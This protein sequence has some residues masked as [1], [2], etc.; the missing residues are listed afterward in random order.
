MCIYFFIITITIFYKFLIDNQ[1]YRINS[2][3]FFAWFRWVLQV[4]TNNFSLCNKKIS[5]QKY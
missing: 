3:N 2:F 5:V 1:Y 4:V